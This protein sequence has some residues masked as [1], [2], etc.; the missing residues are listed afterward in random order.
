MTRIVCLLTLAALMA[1]SDLTLPAAAIPINV[2]ASAYGAK[3]NGVADDTAAI[4]KAIAVALTPG[5]RF[6]APAVVWLPKGTYRIT[7]TLHGRIGTTTDSERSGLILMGEDRAGTIIRL[8]ANAAGFRDAANPKPLIRTCG[9]WDANAQRIN[10]NEAFKNGVQNLTIE[11]GTGNAGAV[12]IDWLVSNRGAISNVTLRAADGAG[13]IGIRMDRAWPGPGA[14][15]DTSIEGFAWGLTLR[16][17]Y[18]FGITVENLKL[19]RQRSAGI[20]VERNTLAIRKLDYEGTAPAILSLDAGSSGMGLGMLT[21]MDSVIR[22]L[23]GATGAAIVS[24]RH[25]L[26]RNLTCTGFPQVLDDRSPGNADIAGGAATKTVTFHAIGPKIAVNGEVLRP[27]GLPVAE[28]PT[29]AWPTDPA[30]VAVVLGD[31]NLQGAIDSGKPALA[32]NSRTNGKVGEYRLFDTIRIGAQPTVRRIMGTETQFLARWDTA[33]DDRPFLRFEG[34]AGTTVVIEHVRFQGRIEHAGAGTLVFRHCHLGPYAAS[35]AGRTF[36]VDTLAYRMDLGTQHQT[37][38]RQHNYEG[39][40][41]AE[42]WARRPDPLIVNHGKLWM[43]G[44]K[45]EGMA[46]LIR[47]IGGQVELLGGFHYVNRAVAEGVPCFIN[48]NGQFTTSHSLIQTPWPIALREVD[49]SRTINIGDGSFRNGRSVALLVSRTGAGALADTTAPATPAAPIVSGSVLRPT[50]SGAAEPGAAVTILV[51]GD[52]VAVVAADDAGAWRWTLRDDL[53]P[54][55]HAI[56][57]SAEDAAGNISAASPATSATVPVEDSTAPATP[58]APLASGDD[59]VL[60]TLSGT[61]EPFAR[62]RL[63]DGDLLVATVA[64]DE[65]G[66]WHATP[67]SLTIGTHPFTV[68]A[69]DAAGNTSGRSPATVVTVEERIDDVLVDDVPVVAAESAGDED[70]GGCGLGGG[71]TLFTLFMAGWAVRLRPR[72]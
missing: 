66:A 57:V 28:V 38:L 68:T 32:I 10:G 8:G 42:D 58:A 40:C 65:D 45:T 47:N 1:A 34:V 7:N 14:I 48:D 16:D 49:G 29:I 61:T 9:E 67:G 46:T 70:G 11:I 24:Q 3:G 64:A 31:G 23:P 62:V 52:T 37:W 54:G 60:P 27:L 71:L 56:T 18:Q 19:R 25:L 5:M 2:R 6:A 41:T 63:Y 55:T 26:I 36:M 33:S 15:L 35:G 17:H 59:A 69:C 43:F 39:P 53:A 4:Q 44:H 72:P 30:Q 13:A 20:A 22:A 21:L 51:D 50:V 12:G